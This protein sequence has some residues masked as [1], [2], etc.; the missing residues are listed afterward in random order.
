M[1]NILDAYLAKISSNNDNNLDK[2]VTII[3]VGRLA[4][5]SKFGKRRAIEKR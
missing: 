1:K 3:H 2:D 4:G 5:C